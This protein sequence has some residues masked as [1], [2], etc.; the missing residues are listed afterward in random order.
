MK[1][2]IAVTAGPG[3]AVTLAR[4]AVGRGEASVVA[5]GGDGT[6]SEVANSLARSTAA[7]GVIAVGTGNDLARSMGL[8]L[9]NVSRALDVIQE[10]QVRR[11]DLGRAGDRYFVSLLGVGFPASVAR[12][13]NDMRFVTGTAAFLLAVCRRIPQMQAK[14][15]RLEI[16]GRVLECRATS[17]LVQNTPFTGGGLRIAPEAEIDD[18]ELDVV[19]VDEIGKLDLF[20]NLPRVY[21][22]RHIGHPHF[23][24][25][26]CRSLRIASEEPLEQT[27]DGDRFDLTPL[28]VEVC[29]GALAMIAP[30][31]WSAEG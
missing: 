4:A 18:G 24:T 1:G 31:G 11:V 16:D 21:R 6:V 23:S 29:P 2:R 12:L 8:P 25:Y 27:I 14:Q 15:I 28:N 3:D 7:M 20:W 19:V 13:A 30:G 5:V 17:I 9:K 22:G 26:R 10:N